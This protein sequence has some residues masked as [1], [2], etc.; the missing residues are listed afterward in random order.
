MTTSD[1][2]R[3]AAGRLRQ[4]GVARD[5]TEAYVLLLYCIGVSPQLPAGATYQRAC[6]RLADLIDPMCRIP[7]DR[8][9]S[10]LMC[11]PRLTC[12]ACGAHVPTG[13]GYRYCPHCGARVE[14]GER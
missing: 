9:A 5:A 4:G 13:V 12:T 11:G 3:E 1:E 14:E 2:R 10:A 7:Y 8:D 6:G